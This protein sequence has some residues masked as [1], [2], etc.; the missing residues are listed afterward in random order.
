MVRY[1]AWTWVTLGILGLTDE[2]QTLLDSI[3]VELGEMRLSL[4]LGLQGAFW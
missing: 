1:V 2:A 3:A 4:W